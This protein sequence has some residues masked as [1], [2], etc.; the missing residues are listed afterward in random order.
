MNSKNRELLM[1]LLKDADDY[2]EFKKIE[3]PPIYLL[4]GSGCRITS[5]NVC[6]TKLL[7]HV[8]HPVVARP[9]VRIVA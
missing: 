5:Y 1:E 4:G 3:C 9:L 7:R 2:A 6:Y 8:Q